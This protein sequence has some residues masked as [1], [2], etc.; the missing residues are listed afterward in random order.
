MKSLR[1]AWHQAWTT[2]LRGRQ[3]REMREEFAHHIEMQTEEN[4]R[5]GMDSDAA[6]R[7]ARMKFGSMEATEEA[8]R[9]QRGVRWVEESARDLRLGLH[10]LK[11]NPAFAA[12]T[13]LTLG[14]TIGLNLAIYGVVQNVLLQPLPFKEPDRLVT[15]YNSFPGTGADRLANNVPDFF[16]RRERAT[17]LEEVALYV[18]SGE[19]VGEGDR[20]ER[21]PGLRVTPSFFPTLGVEAALGRTFLEKEMDP[22][23]AA[24]VILT[25]GYWRER[26]G[27]SPDVLGRTL[28]IDGQKAT[29]VG[30]LPGSFRLPTQPEARL[31]HPLV[32][33]PQ[34][35]SLEAWG[36][37]NDFFMLGRLAPG[38]SP[39]RLEAELNSLY[40]SVAYEMR[41]EEGVR[42]LE[43]IGFRTIVVDAHVDLVRNVRLPLF[44]L[45]GAVSFVLLIGCVNIANLILARSE[46]RL[47]EMATRV[48]L[49]AGRLRLVRQILSEATLIGVLGGIVGIGLASIVLPL[50]GVVA[51]SPTTSTDGNGA[52]AMALD[53]LSFGGVG[54]MGRSSA[55]GLSASVLGYSVA[56]AVG[57]S[58]V[59][60]L[61]PIVKLFRNDLNS[62]FTL[63]GRGRTRSRRGMLVH[64]TL[65]AGQVAMAF[66]LLVGA[67]L[68]LR[69]FGHVVDVDP[70]FLRDGVFTGYTSLTNVRYP[71]GD[72]RR[73]FYDRFLDSIRAL[74]GVE[75][76]SVTNLLPFGPG[77]R[78]MSITP[79]GSE[80]R[81]GES[82]VIPNWSVV[83]PGYF[84]A[85]GIKVLEGRAFE[86]R[87]GP[88][89][90]QVILI[91]D[92]LAKYF[93]PDR[94]ALGR[95]I[96]LPFGKEPWTVIGVVRPVKLKDLTSAA[97]DHV[98]AFYLTYRQMP[99]AD[100]ALVVR[101]ADTNVS[102]AESVRAALTRLDPNVPLYDAQ[103]LDQRLSQSLGSR[104]TPM[105][106]LVSF[107]VIAVFLAA[108]GTF[109]VVA[110]SVEQ[111]RRE[112]AIRMAL[113]S[114]PVDIVAMVLKQGVVMAALGLAA[115]AIGVAFM[116]RLI[117]SL[118]FGVEPL[119]P[120]VL[121]A[122]AA[123]LS[124][125]VVL[126]C[127]VPARRA[128]RVD[129]MR[130]LA[131][132]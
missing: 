33:S 32:F 106:L 47:P 114:R 124:L 72:A 112:T 5:L 27:A 15:L 65:V 128:T 38:T 60:G 110:Y 45:W 50:L 68:M 26:F 88:G 11:R 92:W 95:Q 51:L 96:R 85:L 44:L 109:G 79:V 69:S 113:G 107:A 120:L 28:E 56:L 6:R 54:S 2:F 8:W 89:Q 126:A 20:V 67:G 76:A 119:D 116:V 22:G 104:R 46:A 30:V 29:I 13:I 4:L 14:V 12:V 61:I 1:R 132:E 82:T 118:L 24:T 108:V 87:D 99:S 77:D 39:E 49:G 57:T 62:A 59:F 125:S 74:P 53:L 131:Q 70:G 100:M 115:G 121:G 3:E 18:G 129:P 21:V 16:L 101:A 83:G 25:D 55:V 103:T 111:R 81:P 19:N 75:A 10:A 97:S 122:T 23:E 7:E 64:S 9:D 93:W 80:L 73:E 78:T 102:I 98:G 105:I 17:G 40:R 66:L 42:G 94:S 71:D 91:D 52:G 31:V 90:Q 63:E 123:V 34:Q 58:L 127:L 86:E 43:K 37:N 48:A 117:P 84:D 35:R 41:G 130:A 36:S